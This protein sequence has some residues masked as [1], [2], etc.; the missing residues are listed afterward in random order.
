MY[1]LPQRKK[2]K[3]MSKHFQ[4]IYNLQTQIIAFTGQQK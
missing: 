1:I 4:K 3:K 2:K